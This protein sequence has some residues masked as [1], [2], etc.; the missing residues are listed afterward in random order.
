MNDFLTRRNFL[1]LGATGAAAGVLGLAGHAQ[2]PAA[3]PNAPSPRSRT[4]AEFIN[5]PTQAAIDRGLE[6]LVR[7]QHGDGSFSERLTGATVGI[8]SLAGL[9]LMAA[10]NQPG[11]GKYGR[12]VAKTVEYVSSM[13]NGPMTGFL[14]TPDSQSAPRLAS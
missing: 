5:Q 10:G 9:A 7:S 3:T 14:T 13:A 4:G 2:Q 6:F 11:R 12:Q 1:R 8:T